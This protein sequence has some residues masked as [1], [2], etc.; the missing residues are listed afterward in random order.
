MFDL[1]QAIAEWRRQMGAAGLETPALLDE[2]E[3]HL[4]DDVEAQARSGV[5]LPEAW[6]AAVQRIGPAVVL[7]A[8]FQKSGGEKWPALKMCGVIGLAGTVILNLAGFFVFH[9][10][11]S[12]LFSEV[13]WSIWFPNYIGWI[14]F[15]LI[16]L[17]GG[18]SHR[19]ATKP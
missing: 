4:R 5:S 17:A 10:D 15:L 12:V 3:G 8:E 16:G 6:Q 18:R 14:T 13:W 9:K 19:D 2:L 7:Q 1:E 11:S